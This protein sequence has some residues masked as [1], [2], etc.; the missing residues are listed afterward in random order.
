[1]LFRNDKGNIFGGY[2]SI[3]WTNSGNWQLAPDSFLF[4]LTNIY[5][6]QPTKF[7]LNNNNKNQI[8]F[9]SDYGPTFGHNDLYFYQAFLNQY[10][11]NCQSYFPA[12]FEDNLGKGKSIF[13][14]DLNN[15]NQYIKLNEIEIFKIV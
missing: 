8:Y 15:N 4:T 10:N 3:S 2:V 5:N 12:A 14:G 11:N 7:E 1:M 9:N 13:T 6:T